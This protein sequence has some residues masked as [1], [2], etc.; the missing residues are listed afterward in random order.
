MS[1]YFGELRIINIILKD[2]DMILVNNIHNTY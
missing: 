1:L 2:G